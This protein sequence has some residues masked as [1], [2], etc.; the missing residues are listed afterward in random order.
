MNRQEAMERFK[1][2]HQETLKLAREQFWQRAQSQEYS[3]K[4]AQIL[5]Q[6]FFSLRAEVERTD[7]DKLMFFYFSLLRVDLLNRNYHVKVQ[8]FDAR[9]YLDTE[10]L[11]LTFSLAELFE[12]LNPVWDQLLD[13]TRKYIDKVNTYDVGNIMQELAMECNGLLAHQ[14]RFML[15]DIEENRD[16]AGTPKE[17]VWSIR[18]GEYR[19]HSEVIAC[20]DRIAKDQQTWERSVRKAAKKEKPEHELAAGYWYGAELSNTDCR[21]L[22]MYFINFEDC[23]LKHIC[24]NGANMTGARFRNCRIESCSFQGAVLR[25]ADF[26]GC[27]WNN[28]DFAGADVTNA[29]FMEQELPFIH[30]EAEQLQTILIDRRQ[31]KA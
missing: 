19:D 11:E 7:K 1:E 24:F 10:P 23:T 21:D 25:Q 27:T 2:E 9:W 6:V 13:G 14:L 20:A 12:I 31:E 4:L 18:W 16:F 17:K 30:L 26:T 29:V 15:R 5:K 28:N 3:D 22:P 8:A